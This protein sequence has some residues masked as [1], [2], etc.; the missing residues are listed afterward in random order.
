MYHQVLKWCNLIEEILL[1][2]EHSDCTLLL[3][4]YFGTEIIIFTLDD[5]KLLTQV[6]R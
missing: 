2:G 5:Q 3:K 6:S 1:R 4:L